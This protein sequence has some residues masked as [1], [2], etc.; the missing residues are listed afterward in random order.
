MQE[1]GFDPCGWEDPYQRK[2]LPTLKILA[3]EIPSLGSL[4]SYRMG[5][6][7]VRLAGDLQFNFSHYYMVDFDSFLNF[8]FFFVGELR[9][10]WK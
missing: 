9:Q 2:W 6:Q 7:R 5:S 3:W 1:T 10:V 8:A 4:A